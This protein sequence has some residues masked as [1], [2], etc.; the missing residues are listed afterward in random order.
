MLTQIIATS[1]IAAAAS[2][3]NGDANNNI[4]AYWGQN[5]GGSQQSLGEY[6]N[7]TSADIIIMSFMNGFPNLELNFAN[8][9]SSTFSDGLLHCSNIG[10][11][12]KSCQEEGKLVL[13]SLGGATGT[14]GFTSDS[15]AE[16]FATTMWNKFGG[17]QDD[18]RPFDDAIVDGF[19][20]DIENQDQT[21]YVALANQLRQY[22]N[23]DSSKKYYLSAAP[24]CPYPDQ[25][26]GDLLSQAEIDFCFIQ[27]Y[28]NYCSVNGQF[29]WQTWSTY[30]SSTSPNKDIKLYLGLPGSATSAGS[31]YVGL[32]EV[33]SALGSIGDD[34]SFGG[35]SVW[36]ISSA[37][38][39]GFLDGL[40]NLLGSP[41]N[42]NT[43]TSSSD[44]EDKAVSTS[45]QTVS[46][47]SSANPNP[48]MKT[49]YTTSYTTIQVAAR[50][51]GLEKRA[52][53]NVLQG[54]SSKTNAGVNCSNTTFPARTIYETVLPKLVSQ[55]QPDVPY[56][57]GSAWAGSGKA[58]PTTGD[59]HQ[60]NVWHG[61]QEKY[62]NWYKLRR[63]FVS[64][65]GMEPSPSSKTYEQCISDPTELYPQSE[66]VD[67]DNKADGFERRLAL[68]V[69]ENI[70]VQGLD[71]DSWIYATQLMQAECLGYAYRCWRREWRGEGKRYNGGTYVWQ[72]N[73]C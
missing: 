65:F 32:S 38:Q 5:A 3:F 25:S 15:D 14:Y 46:P 7:S 39:D 55:Y 59:L 28:N 73:D 54:E 64:E 47:T 23:G 22:F 11:D 49:V 6:C 60:C 12:I 41:E 26:V 34:S 35:I 71:F 68:Y 29:N 42:S 24:Q 4:A 43:P 44:E 20:F 57:P 33:Q 27:F 66:T 16:S 67:H 69:I 51:T 19:D 63:R 50:A 18:E 37:E 40:R 58:D 1:L 17:G 56:H 45:A 61:S 9:C 2:A 36:D 72:I 31:G 53:A 13:L 62:Q 10:Q 48:P 21:G 52:E 30:A 8:Q 70:K